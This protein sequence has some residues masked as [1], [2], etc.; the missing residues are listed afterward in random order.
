MK[1]I[2]R[3]WYR[4][5][6]SGN[7]SPFPSRNRATSSLS[8]RSPS[9]GPD[10]TFLATACAISSSTNSSS[11]QALELSALA[12]SSTA[13]PPSSLSLR[14]AGIPLYLPPHRRAR[15]IPDLKPPRR[16]RSGLE[17]SGHS[18]R[19]TPPPDSARNAPWPCNVQNV[20]VL[21]PWPAAPR[22]GLWNTRQTAAGGLVPAFIID[23]RRARRVSRCRPDRRRPYLKLTESLPKVETA[24]GLLV[25]EPFSSLGRPAVSRISTG[26][27]VSR[28]A[29]K[30][31]TGPTTTIELCSVDN[32]RC[33]A[34]STS[35]RVT[36][37]T[38]SR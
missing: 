38:W 14:I 30:S 11:D 10:S 32:S 15:S 27:R 5:T 3:D 34:A 16:K 7:A 28:S 6:S 25:Q 29:W 13:T 24:H 12:A 21:A 17:T 9:V 31:R 18:P 36:A 22:R 1:F 33:A 2:R 37:A 26:P 19:F 23:A 35:S 20:L 4:R 8:G